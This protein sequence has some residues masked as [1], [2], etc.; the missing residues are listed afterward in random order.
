MLIFYSEIIL[1]IANYLEVLT[2]SACIVFIF[3]KVFERMCGEI[4]K[5]WGKHFNKSFFEKKK[6]LQFFWNNNSKIFK[7]KCIFEVSD[8]VLTWSNLPFFLTFLGLLSFTSNCPLCFSLSD[9]V[10]PLIKCRESWLLILK[11]LFL[12]TF[13]MRYCWEI[14]LLWFYLNNLF[15][16]LLNCSVHQ[17]L[18]KFLS[19]T[20]SV[21][22]WNID[23][24][25]PQS[26]CSWLSVSNIFCQRMVASQG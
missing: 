20:L 23:I 25:L 21:A 11:W 24:W 6:I 15:N 9:W 8:F 17:N 3:L 12:S 18:I 14:F 26:F 2:Y 13:T 5:S 4:V 1:A 19:P 10:N 16:Q 22:R 7:T